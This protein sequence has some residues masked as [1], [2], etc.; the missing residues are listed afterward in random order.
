[1]LNA[2]NTVH[3]IRDKVAH[4]ELGYYPYYGR[5]VDQRGGSALSI[6]RGGLNSEDCEKVAGI[7]VGE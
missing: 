3:R 2:I 7:E 1:V 6:G 5:E 4:T